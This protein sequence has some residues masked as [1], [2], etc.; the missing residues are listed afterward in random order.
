VGT[1]NPGPTPN[2]PENQNRTL[3]NRKARGLEAA[4]ELGKRRARRFVVS[5]LIKQI[6]D[7]FGE[8][9][10]QLVGDARQLLEDYFDDVL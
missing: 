6:L 5:A 10:K 3:N 7:E 8:D 1:S 9:A 2:R 4:A